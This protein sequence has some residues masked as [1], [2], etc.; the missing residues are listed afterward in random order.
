MAIRIARQ[1]TKARRW[2]SLPRTLPPSSFG[3]GMVAFA[4]G[5]LRRMSV[6]LQA[7]ETVTP[8]DGVPAAVAHEG[9]DVSLY[10]GS[11]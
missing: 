9:R 4:A 11:R 1:F 7:A 10:D 8:I 3:I 6:F 2:L 5:G